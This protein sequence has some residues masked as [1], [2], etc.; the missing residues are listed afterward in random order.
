MSARMAASVM[1]SNGERCVPVGS[2]SPD[3]S[4]QAP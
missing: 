1:S 3:L 4:T 2:S